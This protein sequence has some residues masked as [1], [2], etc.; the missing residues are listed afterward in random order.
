MSKKK[1][2]LAVLID[3]LKLPQATI[4]RRTGLSVVYIK[5][6]KAGSRIPSKAVVL[7]FS[8]AFGV[9]VQ[10]LLGKRGSNMK[11]ETYFGEAWTM[12]IA[13]SIQRRKEFDTKKNR[14]DLGL[15]C[16]FWLLVNYDRLA[17]IVSAAFKKKKAKLALG[18]VDLALTD[19]MKTF[20]VA[21]APAPFHLNQWL[22]G[23]GKYIE[24]KGPD[25][26]AA[27]IVQRFFAEIE[28]EVHAT[29]EPR[30]QVSQGS[31]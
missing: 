7:A 27:R 20:D 3:A 9:D 28:R 18:R 19:L 10:W 21:A 17:R 22:K 13:S 26:A 15:S 1:T 24:E 29:V 8:D 25:L 6:L 4:A 14:G 30:K 31:K 12:E 2:R 5:K 23:N 11:V 16:L